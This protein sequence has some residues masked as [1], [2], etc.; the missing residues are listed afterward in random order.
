MTKTI[1]RLAEKRRKW[2]EANRENGFE[3][4]LKRLLT[5]LYPDN[6]HFVYELLQNAEDAHA[7]EV[8]FI[9]YQD[10]IEFVH[11]GKKLF[12]IDDID[13]ITSIG[14]STKREDVTKIGKFGVGFKAVFSYTDSPEIESDVFHFQIHDMVV[15]KPINSSIKS[16]VSQQTKFVLPFN[17]TRK[18]QDRARGE[19]EKILRGLDAT[20]VLFLTHIKKIEYVLPDA[21]YG[22]IERKA[23]DNNRFEIRVQQPNVTTLS[24]AWFLKYDKE[25]YV[26]DEEAD[27]D[28]EKVKLCCIAVAFGLSPIKTKAVNKGDGAGTTPEWELQPI[29]PGRVCIYFPADKETTNLR[30]H[31]HAPFAS[32]VAR[33]SVRDCMG[34][35]SLRDHLAD[36]LAESMHDIRDQGLLT[37]RSLVLLPNDKDNLPVFYHPLLKRLVREFQEQDLVPMKR[38]G[39]SPAS[40]IFRGAKALSDLIDDDDL[41]TLLG[42]DYCPPMWV[43]NPPQRNQRE[44]NFLS[45]LEIEEWTIDNLVSVLSELEDESLAQWLGAKTDGWH[46]RLYS[47][48]EDYADKIEEVKFIRIS[49]GTYSKGS[50]CFFPSEDVESDEQFP[51]VAREIVFSSKNKE[52]QKRA[53]AFLEHIGVREVDE[54]VEVEK[55]LESK[56]NYMSDKPNRKEHYSHIRQFIQFLKKYPEKSRMF[57]RS[58][59][60]MV[61][62]ED[63][64]EWAWPSGVYLD[65]P[66]LQTGLSA[67][68]DMPEVQVTKCPL[69]NVYE[70]SGIKM[71]KIGEFARSLGASTK[72][73]IKSIKIDCNHPEWDNLN[74]CG[75]DRWNENG[76]NDDYHI[77]GLTEFLIEPSI[78]KSKLIWRTMEELCGSECP[79]YLVARFGRNRSR[80]TYAKSTIVH[81]LRR[82]LWIPQQSGDKTSFVQPRDAVAEKLPD[83]YEFQT[84]WRWLKDI[85]FGVGVEEQREAQRRMREKQ[86]H[87]Y[88]HKED[89]ARDMGFESPEEAEEIARLKKENPEEFKKFKEGVSA[90]KERVTFPARPVANPER[91]QDRLHEQLAEAQQKEYS[92]H[93]RSVRTTNGAIDPTTW[94]RNQYN[95]ESDQMVCQICKK[96]MPFR[97]R[98]GKH[99]FVKKEVLSRKFLPKEHEA[100]YLALCPL[101]A[102]K[103]DEFVKT[104]DQIMAELMQVIVNGDNCEIPISLGEEKTSIR[105]VETHYHDLKAIIDQ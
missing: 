7:K 23:Y 16:T 44:D 20:T 73:E 79:H 65:A 53:R 94:L 47:F 76:K 32:T 80:I 38:G 100:Q 2:V 8:R 77:P 37:V 13:A 72:L 33:D 1:E 84:G 46:Q 52:Q 55:I 99:Y 42:D 50:D 93:G 91:R 98:D 104:D 54:Q 69:S 40:G 10:R 25:I 88:K 62:L 71:E 81:D 90:R 49:D 57:K 92:Q 70:K 102:A 45:T 58:R 51:R 95:N 35:K 14:F 63:N 36:L 68:Y 61:D 19:I 96:E 105:F 85:E 22:F 11:D 28:D 89:V 5:E 103:Y 21:S 83:G 9:L 78:S 101:C 86:K 24:S 64:V 60:F 74:R 59:L 43:T 87:G 34:N 82:A 3:T 18:T 75:G 17:N 6:A 27:A 41:V 15:P 29:D 56:Y 4:G 48:L 26:E 67:Y 66:Y 97:K 12:T 30:F 31:L 39:H